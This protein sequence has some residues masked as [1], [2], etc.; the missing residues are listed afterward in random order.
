MLKDSDILE[1]FKERYKAGQNAHSEY[2]AEDSKT[3]KFYAGEQW[4]K[5]DVQALEGEQRPALT[6]NSVAPIINAVSGSE[7]TNRYEPRFLPRTTSD[8][9]INDV[10]TETVRYQRQQTDANH[11]ESVAFRDC[12]I[13]GIGATEFYYS[14]AQSEYGRLVVERVPMNELLWDPSSKKGNLV[15]ARWLMRGKWIPEKEFEKLWGKEALDNVKARATDYSPKVGDLEIHD[16]TVSNL[17]ASEFRFY[18]NKL[19]KV[20]VFDYQFIEVEDYYI[21]IDLASGART[22]MTGAEKANLDEEMEK[23]PE[24]NRLQLDSIKMAKDVHYRAF[25]AGDVVLEASKS[26]IQNFSYKFMTGFMEQSSD[27][28]QWFGLMRS[29]VDPQRWSNKML[30]QLVHTVATNPKGAIL[31]EDGV[32][33]NPAQA[34]QDWGKPNSIITT[35]MGAL[36]K[37]E[38]Q[39]VSGTYPSSMERIMELAME[40]IPRVSGVN[41]YMSGQVDDL[42]RTAQSAVQLVQRQGMVIL[43]ALFDSLSRYRR[44]AGRLHLDFVD[45]YLEEGTIVRVAKDPLDPVGEPTEFKRD[46]IE[47]VEYDVIVDEAPI[48][49]SANM[50]FW[51]T[52]MQ[53]DAFG[54]MVESGMLTM[55]IVADIMP[56]VPTSVRTR[57]KE[58]Y[59]QAV[60]A[61]QQQPQGETIQ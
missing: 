36:K 41:P 1:E 7:I 8:S 23:L 38:V 17:Y 22:Y 18:D 54:T 58:N 16:Q 2:H 52:L 35:R 49:P 10:L 40:A 37:K 34:R 44:E 47:N 24:E 51:Q 14:Y 27:G 4:D 9:E 39:I 12:V 30:S 19:Q 21:V 59:R 60:E 6:F 43:S 42:R 26:R 32:F 56:N 28:V 29:M 11:E 61:A 45:A 31:A 46:W 48:S 25:I 20:A 5:M 55:D 13:A 3:H 15:D 53:T 33:K 57:M 50:D